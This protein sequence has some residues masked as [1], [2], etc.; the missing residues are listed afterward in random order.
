MAS[1]KN[2]FGGRADDQPGI[3]VAFF[4]SQNG[5]CQGQ[6]FHP[7]VSTGADK[8][9][10]DFST[11]QLSGGGGIIYRMRFGDRRFQFI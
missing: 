7:A 10:L 9:L 5:G 8:D 1:S 2:R 11:F 6:V 4:T 3:R